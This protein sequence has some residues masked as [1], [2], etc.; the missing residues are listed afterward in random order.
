MSPDF[1]LEIPFVLYAF[2]GLSNCVDFR[3]IM[4]LEFGL[5][6]ASQGTM[7]LFVSIFEGFKGC[8]SSPSGVGKASS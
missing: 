3:V 6:I 4:S 2:K 5:K 7:L 8:I 1:T